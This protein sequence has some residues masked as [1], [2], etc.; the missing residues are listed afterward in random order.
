VSELRASPFHA[1]TAAANCDNAWLTRNGMTLSSHFTSVEQEVLAARTAVAI[2]DISARWRLAIEGAAAEAFLARLVTRDPAALAPG[3]AFKALWLSDAGGVRG[4]GV[5]ARFGRETFHLI[6]A[7][8]DADWIGAAADIAGARARDVSSESGGIAVIGPYA[9]A[10]L[11]GAGLETDVAPLAFRKLSW[12]G[13]DVT[14]S[15]WGEHDGYEIWCAGD[16]AILVWDR[17]IRAGEPFGISPAGIA[18]TDLLDI[19]AGIARPHLDYRPAQARDDAEP[20]P[21]ALGLKR[22]IDAE[23]KG[24]NGQKGYL[25]A[26]PARR[27]VGVEFDTVEPAPFTPLTLKDRIVGH[28]LRSVHSPTLRRAIALASVDV[29]AA[30]EGTAFELSLPPHLAAPELRKAAARVVGLPF[31]T[32]PAS[33][34]A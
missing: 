33:I 23:H 20:S 13:L 5:V 28:T 34:G 6:A 25:A 24:F 19:E 21:G 10:T 9:K 29:A 8:P 18:A 32:A 4:A 11:K 1:R 30:A 15:R 3:A 12:R 22:L 16:D 2:A 27:L 26:K 17:L 7:A 14:L 31:V